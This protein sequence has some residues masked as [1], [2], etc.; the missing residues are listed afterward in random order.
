MQEHLYQD[1]YELEETHWWHL[2]KRR[3]C[4]GLF[5][6]FVK[7]PR[8]SILDIGCGTGKNVETFGRVGSAWGVDL[9]KEA[10]EFCRK[11]GLTNV[12]LEPA[13]RTRF[14]D[15]SFDV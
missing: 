6:T 14:E 8:P 5:S 4:L 3:V 10:I 15:S 2:A 1:L 12:C 11:R 7:A 9:S 13:D